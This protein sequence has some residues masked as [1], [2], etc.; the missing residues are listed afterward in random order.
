[1][2][3]TLTKTAKIERT[4]PLAGKSFG[5]A[6][7]MITAAPDAYRCNL[8]AGARAL[9]SL[10]KTLGVA[11]PKAPKTS[12]SSGARSAL[13]LGPDEWLI[14]DEK[15]DPIADLAAVKALHSAVDVSHRNTAIIVSGSRAANVINAGCPQDLTLA[16]F[17]VGACSRTV[18]GKIEI[19]LFRSK[20]DEFRVEVWRSFSTYAFE[21]LSTAAKHG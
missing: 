13:W 3:K 4:H 14:V 20:K 2:A 10:S 6:G 7:V 1:M 15:N 9:T 19:V 18:L 5:G 21:L 17:P 16:A 8:R 12:V 11:L